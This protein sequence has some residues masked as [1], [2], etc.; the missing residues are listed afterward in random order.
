MSH[1]CDWCPSLSRHLPVQPSVQ[2]GQQKDE[3]L[4]SGHHVEC[5]PDAD[6]Q[7]RLLLFFFSFVLRYQGHVGVDSQKKKKSKQTN[8]LIFVMKS[9]CYETNTSICRLVYVKSVAIT[10]GKRRA[11]KWNYV[12]V[13]LTARHFSSFNF[14]VKCHKTCL[15]RVDNTRQFQF[16]VS[17]QNCLNCK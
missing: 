14:T 17:L 5:E 13:R 4:T 15:L 1:R 8:E 10:L 6:L 2:R 11:F 9:R 16:T 3:Q 12:R 7:Y